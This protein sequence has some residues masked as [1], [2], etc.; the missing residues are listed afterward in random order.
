[1]T[2]RQ[3]FEFLIDSPLPTPQLAALSDESDTSCRGATAMADGTT[4]APLLSD[5]S[6]RTCSSE[7]AVADGAAAA[8][9][10]S[11]GSDRPCSSE[12]AAAEGSAP[13]GSY[14]MQYWLG[15]QLAA[16]SVVDIL[17]GCISSVYCFWSKR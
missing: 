9:P 10:L 17:P 6:V 5:G 12:A 16:V 2:R 1:M 14:H 8:L 7:A 11:D 15:S 4:A 13:Y 3:F